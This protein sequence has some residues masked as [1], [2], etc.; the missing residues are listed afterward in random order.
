[1]A[2]IT[3]LAGGTFT[4]PAA[5]VFANVNTGEIDLA[6]STV[7]GPYT[8]TYTTP[9]PCIS[10]T[11]YDISILPVQNVSFSLNNLSGNNGD[12]ILIPVI[13]Q[14]FTDILSAQFTLQWDPAIIQLMDVEN[15]A[16]LT[17]LDLTN[18][19]SPDAQTLIFTW[20]TAPGQSLADGLSLFDMRFELIGQSCNSSTIRFIGSPVPILVTD[21]NLCNANVVTTNG[22]IGVLGTGVSDAP[23]VAFGDT[24]NCIN[25]AIPVLSVSG[26][27]IKWY[28]DPAL[29]ILVATTNDYIPVIDNTDLADTVFYATQ[30][31]G[32]CSESLPDSSRIQYISVPEPPSIPQPVYTLCLFA[33]PPSLVASGTNVQWFA[34]NALTIKLADGNTFIP[35]PG[36]LD[37]SFE[38]TTIFYVTQD[39]QCGMS[40]YS[41]VQVDMIDCGVNCNDFETTASAQNTSCPESKD[42]TIDIT[43]TVPVPGTNQFSLD[44]GI[45]Y[46]D[47]NNPNSTQTPDTLSVGTYEILVRALGSGCYPDTSLVNIESQVIFTTT[48][49]KVEPTCGMSDGEITFS[50]AGGSGDYN[51]TLHLPNGSVLSNTSGVFTGL[52]SGVYQYD[53]LDNNSGCTLTLQEIILN[54]SNAITATADPDSFENALCYGEPMGRAIINVSGGT[55]NSY[56]YSLN[57]NTWTDF[58]SGEYIENLPPNGTYIVLIRQSAADL[59]FEQVQVTI[60]NEYPPTDF[61]YS[62]T[63]ASCDLEDGSISI[64]TITGGAAPYEISFEFDPFIAVDLNNLPVFNN[65]SGGFKNIRIQDVNGCIFENDQV[66]VDFPG[67][68]IADVQRIPPTCAGEGKDGIVSV[69][70]GSN[71]N[72]ILPPFQ[73]GFASAG[74]P[75]NEVVLQPILPDN[76]VTIDTL[77]NGSYYVLFS[78]ANGCPSRMDIDVAGG[79]FAIDFTV[80]QVNDAACKGGTGSILIENIT[81]D[82]NSDF[83]IEL[84][85]MPSLDPVFSADFTYGDISGGLTIDGMLA[86][87]F[88]AGE[89]RIQIR[90][91]QNGCEL[92]AVSDNF[93]ISEPDE[94]F[95]FN[96]TGIENSLKNLP[97]GSISILLLPS[98]SEPYETSLELRTPFF[99][100]QE[101]IRDWTGFPGGSGN[102]SFT[103]EELYSGIYEV[104]VRDQLG[105]LITQEVTVGYDSAL[106]IPNIFTPNGD[107]YNDYF[108][109]S[110]LPKSGSGTSLVITNRWGNIIFESDDYNE[111]NLWNGGDYPD[112]TY[113]YRLNIPNQG[114]YSGWIEIWRG[115]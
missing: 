41:E 76:L 98:G 10:N 63:I 11:T 60:N 74:T 39:N 7:G 48:I 78:P 82:V 15:L 112:G 14:G 86:N 9:G 84:I 1:V 49:D 77:E 25:D 52:R 94:Y 42:G 5:I 22:S 83:T 54:D 45:T 66:F 88:T 97:T 50:V 92:V 68:L 44:G 70:I 34:D 43:V 40:S 2:T 4:G 81:G 69:F 96:V 18:F 32:T 103:H 26:V 62:S 8:I 111:N 16:G 3:G 24:V 100:G 71:V 72:T 90:Q 47:F 75:E 91:D 59:C 73:F 36:E 19:N 38:G 93:M 61:A 27:N 85:G 20:S 28:A 46:F 105:C 65:L 6:A 89:Y 35:A 21:N 107:S 29:T 67:Y 31:I 80:S 23:L 113:F 110:N 58:I 33:A 55:D 79:P 56:E 115:H 51:Y 109:I 104:S 17:D 53:V 101:I 114:S 37:T 95:D 30:T 87:G 57:G 108:E 102:Y 99:P 106:L 13:V 12:Q 64:D